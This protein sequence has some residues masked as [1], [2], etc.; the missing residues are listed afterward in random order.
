MREKKKKKKIRK[1]N[2]KVNK[3]L[4]EEEKDLQKVKLESGPASSQQ[5]RQHNIEMPFGGGEGLLPESRCSK[6]RPSKRVL[7]K[8]HQIAPPTAQRESSLIR[9]LFSVGTLAFSRVAKS[10]KMDRCILRINEGKVEF[11]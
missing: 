6:S 1:K 5:I 3:E 7:I 10:F 8:A 4:K 11:T 9:H 2:R